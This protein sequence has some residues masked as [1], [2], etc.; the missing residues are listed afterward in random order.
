VDLVEHGRDFRTDLLRFAVQDQLCVPSAGRGSR[1]AAFVGVEQLI[2]AR[3]ALEIAFAGG[4]L[5]E[6]MGAVQ[7]VLGGRLG[8]RILQ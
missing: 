3:L 4:G 7:P 8:Q 6:L 2:P 5:L 1:L